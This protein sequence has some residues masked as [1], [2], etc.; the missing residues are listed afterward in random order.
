MTSS[1]L[2]LT[3]AERFDW[4]RLLRSENVGPITFYKLLERFGSA[5]AALRAVPEL[6]R[7]GGARRIR[8]ASLA[9]AEK[10]LEDNNRDGA[11]LIARGE[12]F[13]PRLLACIEDAPPLI[14]V[15]G[16]E[17]LLKKKAMASRTTCLQILGND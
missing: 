10:E 16:H 8:V 3:D 13:Y 4:L 7:K 9:D 6:A 5:G 2:R 17:T 12:E 11:R 15:R 14:S 1:L